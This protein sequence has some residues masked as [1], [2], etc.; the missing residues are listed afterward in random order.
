MVIGVA[1]AD[2]QHIYALR[3][4]KCAHAKQHY[5][6]D[7][8]NNTFHFMVGLLV[9]MILHKDNQLFT[10]TQIFFSNFTKR[11]KSRA[12]RVVTLQCKL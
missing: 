3:L 2:K 5:C 11:D 8:K 6:N 12:I 10:A 1:V 9:Y 4:G 7:G